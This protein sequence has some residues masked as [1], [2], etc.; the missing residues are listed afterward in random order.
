M[1]RRKIFLSYRRN[2]IP[3]YV[4]I[5]EEQLEQQFGHGR[6]F[7]DTSDIPGGADWRKTI[8]DNLRESAVLLL[9]IGK[10]WER[11]WNE[12]RDGEENYV[13]YEL[14]MARD[15][16]VEIIPVTVEGVEI[17]RACDLGDIGW[18]RDGQRHDLSDKQRR[19]S[20]DFQ[21]LVGLLERIPGIGPAKSSG[22]RE[23]RAAPVGHSLS[24]FKWLG[25]G[26]GIALLGVLYVGYENEFNDPYTPAPFG[27]DN[28]DPALYGDTH[29]EPIATGAPPPRQIPEEIYGEIYGDTQNR[30]PATSLYGD[31]HDASI[32]ASEE[33]HK[34]TQN[35]PSATSQVFGDT[36][37]GPQATR[38]AFSQPVQVAP[39]PEPDQSGIN[40][41]GTWRGQDGTFYA[42]FEHP[43]G[44]IE[45]QSPGY[46]YGYGMRL[47][48]SP[49][50]YEIELAGVGYGQFSVS[51]DG[52]IID[53]W[54]EVEGERIFDR[55]IR[56]Q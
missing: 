5:L 9:V 25:A 47:R 7:R 40:I 35:R 39:G 54:L 19:W 12:R 15:F 34:D 55:L 4:R 26:A 51:A 46:T 17:S 52:R 6:V 53:G 2:D 14:K 33:L 42:L 16:G 20:S 24:R 32:A 49:G 28:V 31:T 56:V 27:G 37:H 22:Q 44:T 18:I 1:S 30:P 11:L 13:A 3:G 36:Q 41:S 38:D 48:E 8:E 50:S 10:H 43:D 45:M 23:A 21:E 29:N